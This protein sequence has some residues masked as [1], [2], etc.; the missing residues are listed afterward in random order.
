MFINYYILLRIRR[1]F[2]FSLNYKIL[3]IL[4]LNLFI[5]QDIIPCGHLFL[6]ERLFLVTKFFYKIGVN[7]ASLSFE[8]K[9]WKSCDKLRGSVEPSEYKHVVLGLIFLKYAG[10]RF[11][12][13]QEK[14]IEDGDE[15]FINIPSFYVKDNVFFLPENSRWSYIME[16][17]K[18]D[19]IALILD[20][21]FNEIEKNNDKLRG[22]L[23]NN[24]Y[25]RIELET[26]KLSSLLDE[27]NG[28]DT[29]ADNEQDFIGRVY[30]YFL[31]QFAIKEGKGK[32]EFYTPKSVVNL[33]AEIIE[34]YDGTIYDP[35]CG[36]G[37]MFV[38]SLKFI[39]SH[40]GN[41]K[42][43]SVY[44]QEL[45]ATTRRLALMNLAIRGISANLGEKAADTFFNDQHKDQR[46]DYI[47]ANP[48][49]NLKD[50]REENQ[51]ITDYRWSGYEVPPKSNANYAWILH[52]LSKLSD[53][54]VAG[55]VISKGTLN[56]S[57][58]EY[59]IRKKLIE[60][61]LI[62][63]IILLPSKLF[64]TTDISAS[65]WILNKNQSESKIIKNG[66]EVH[67]RNRLNEILFLDLRQMGTPFEKKYVELDYDARLKVV[68]TI[69]S[70]RLKE[71]GYQD[72]PEFSYSAKI[73]EIRTKDYTLVPSQYIEFIDKDTNFDF[74]EEMSYLKDEF[75]DLLIKEQKSTEE[76]LKIFEGL[77]YEIEL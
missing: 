57:G 43:I 70:W 64:Y 41:T 45:T 26:N 46:F 10:D 33:I 30:E 50:W 48:P 16:N 3:N 36:S 28:I 59:N 55:F 8:Q 52:M 73:D 12:Q 4:K 54:G 17:A 72:I 14:L 77:G 20:T 65:I 60:N 69:L 66:E 23:P 71:G 37:G 44:G 9:L 76:L 25:S 63:A 35:C 34:P 5:Y 6:L 68:D 39:E 18:Q 51:L 56:S 19:N 42:N 29:A 67:Y 15:Q 21:A 24:Y 74:D 1:I 22:A 38:Q 7:M 11:D 31:S 47:M 62:E 40:Q 13:Q 2:I 49:F 58:V 75:R 32:G 53:N 61:G 27:I